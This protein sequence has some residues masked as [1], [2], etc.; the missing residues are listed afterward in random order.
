MKTLWPAFCSGA[1]LFSDG[2]VNNSIGTVSTCLKSI[3]GDAYSKS[4]AIS[5]V[6]SIA[7]AGTVVGQLVFGYISDN[8]ARKGG[9]LSANIMLIFL[10]CY[11]R[12]EL[13]REMGILLHYSLHLLFSV[14]LR[15]WDWC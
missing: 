2:Y 11:V 5:N 15:D 6:S 8:I 10:H 13:G 7:F 1:G 3:Y 14:F 4:N 12:L 9:M